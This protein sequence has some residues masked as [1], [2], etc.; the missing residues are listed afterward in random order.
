MPERVENAKVALL[1]ASLEIKN[2]EIDAKIQITDPMQL[3]MFLDQE[4]KTLRQ[5]VETVAATGATVLFCQKGIDDLAQ[6]FLAK[7]NIF[8]VRRVKKSDMEKLSRATG[9]KIV[10]SWKEL[11]RSEEH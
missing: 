4:E 7:K 2:T 9:A 8:A 10:S 3:N 6:H 5:M 1:D 11:T